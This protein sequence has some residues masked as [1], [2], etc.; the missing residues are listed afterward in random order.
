MYIYTD[1]I[2][3]VK[4][5]YYLFLGNIVLKYWFILKITFLAFAIG[6]TCILLCILIVCASGNLSEFNFE[7]I[8]FNWSEQGYFL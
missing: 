8:P 5:K 6:F 7:F 2:K 3:D 1:V 4:Q